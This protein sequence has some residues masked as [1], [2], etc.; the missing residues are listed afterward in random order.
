VLD[1]TSVLGAGRV[2]PFANYPIEAN[3]AVHEL[4]DLCKREYS[5]TYPPNTFA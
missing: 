5:E 4:I 1:P 2:D 3:A